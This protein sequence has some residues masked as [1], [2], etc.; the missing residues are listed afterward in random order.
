[1]KTVWNLFS[2]NILQKEYVI[3]WET[4]CLRDSFG[5]RREMSMLEVELLE[6]YGDCVEYTPPQNYNRWGNGLVSH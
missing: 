6:L 1:M 2:N 3:I 4:G 5:C